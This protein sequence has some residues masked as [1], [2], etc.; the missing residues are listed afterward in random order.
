MDAQE[1]R[2]GM[3]GG[4]NKPIPMVS[5]TSRWPLSVLTVPS[6]DRN[7]NRKSLIGREPIS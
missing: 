3:Y 2:D 7:L 4:K 6:L 1:I 5:M